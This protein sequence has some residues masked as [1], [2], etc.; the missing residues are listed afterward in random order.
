MREE[1]SN[2]KENIKRKREE[3]ENEMDNL[4]RLQRQFELEENK[5][6]KLTGEYIEYMEPEIKEE[7]KQEDTDGDVEYMQLPHLEIKTEKRK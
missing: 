5:R 1:I 2:I 7:M 3:I 6:G 4:D